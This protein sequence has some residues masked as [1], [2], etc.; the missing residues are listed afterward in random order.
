[1]RRLILALTV[2]AGCLC[3]CGV[4]TDGSPVTITVPL[5]RP[6]GSTVPSSG[7]VQDAVFLVHGQHLQAVQRRTAT[8]GDLRQVL[9]LLAAGPSPAE[10]RDGLRTALAPQ[11]IS[12]LALSDRGV[13]TLGVGRQFTGLAGGDQLLAVAQV[14]WTVS[15]FPWVH[16]VRFVTGGQSLEVPTDRGLVQRAVTRVDYGTVAPPPGPA[17]GTPAPPT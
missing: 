2:L 16:R 9:R 6:T 17:S 10:A 5:P 7:S 12:V 3:G 14:V 4:G 15:Q 11:P 8:P 1:V 13:L